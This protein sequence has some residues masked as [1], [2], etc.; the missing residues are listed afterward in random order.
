[1]IH[2]QYA[3]G[4]SR[5]AAKAL[6]GRG[7]VSASC[8]MQRH[9]VQYWLP[10]SE[11]RRL[12]DNSFRAVIYKGSEPISTDAYEHGEYLARRLINTLRYGPSQT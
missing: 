5:P 6:L 11:T 4:P 1:M 3:R 7:S 9:A 10:I 8:I 2:A 12:M